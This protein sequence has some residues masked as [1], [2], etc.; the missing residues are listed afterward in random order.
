[1]KNI[2]FHRFSRVIRGA[3]DLVKAQSST[4]YRTLLWRNRFQGDGPLKRKK[5]LSRAPANVSTFSYGAVKNLHPVAG[6]LIGFFFECRR[7]IAC[8]EMKFPYLLESTDPCLTT[9]HIE[10]FLT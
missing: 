7:T 2:S 10:P 5:T 8:F 6:I 4:G 1:M 3:P 9:V